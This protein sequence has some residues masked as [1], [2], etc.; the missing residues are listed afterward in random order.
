MLDS[1][2]IYDGAISG[3]RVG[4]LQFG[5]FPVIWSNLRVDCLDHINMALHFDGIDDFITLDDVETMKANER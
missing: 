1:G 3:G 5:A 2:D 4:V